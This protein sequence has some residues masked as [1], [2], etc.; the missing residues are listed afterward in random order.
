MEYWNSEQSA[1]INPAMIL[2][3]AFGLSHLP[4]EQPNT[5]G[6]RLRKFWNAQLQ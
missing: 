5:G 3:L 1:R 6:D 2:V 4:G